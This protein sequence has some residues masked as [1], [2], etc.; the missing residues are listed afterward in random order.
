M[1][2]PALFKQHSF[3][4]ERYLNGII[5]FKA[6]Q[7]GTSERVKKFGLTGVGLNEQYGILNVGIDKDVK[8]AEAESLIADL[9]IKST[10]L[11]HR[12]LK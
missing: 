5:P 8:C 2:N 7:D 4:L 3:L 1:M 10:C 12:A 6:K 11:A 9:P